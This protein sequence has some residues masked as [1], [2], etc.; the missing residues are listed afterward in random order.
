[1]EILVLFVLWVLFSALVAAYASGKGRSGGL[2]FLISLLLSPVIGFVIAAVASEERGKP[3]PQVLV[4]A[5]SKKCPDC[6]ELVRAEARKCRFCGFIFPEAT[7]VSEAASVSDAPGESADAPGPPGENVGFGATV[8]IVLVVVALGG[9]ALS[10]MQPAPS[11]PDQSQAAVATLRALNVSLTTCEA[12]KKYPSTLA[13]RCIVG[14]TIANYLPAEHDGYRFRYAPDAPDR[15]T[16]TITA[17]PLAGG[18][19]RHFFTDQSG[20][21]RESMGVPADKYSQA[22]R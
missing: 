22:V 11:V 13:D 20:I 16:Y 12:K 2:Y 15:F 21:I 3:A 1:L 14:H 7:S 17:D 8:L 19:K 10:R 9:F 5:D 4:A 6:A 18:D